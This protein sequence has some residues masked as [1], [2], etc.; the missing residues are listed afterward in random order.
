[1]YSIGLMSGTSMD[2][3]DAALLDTDGISAITELANISISYSM[4]FKI[5]LKALE[6]T[7]KAHVGHL[8]LTKQNFPKILNSYL[9]NELNISDKN[10]KETLQRLSQYL[11][12][13]NHT[14]ITA[15]D[16]IAHST[17][18]HAKAVLSLLKKTNLSA[19][20]IDVIG[21][22][23]QTLFHSPAHKISL[24]I[25]LGDQLADQLGITV[26]NDFR[27]N[28]INHGG[29]GAPFAP[30]YHQ[31]LAIRDHKIPLVV[32]N[33]GGIANVSIICGK[34]E[35]QLFGFDTG[36]GNG[37]IDRYIKQKTHGQE[38][39]DKNG[40]YGLQGNVDMNMFALLY[41]RSIQLHGK[42]FFDIPP[43]KSLDIGD[44]QL[45]EEINELEFRDACAT[46]EAFTA[47]TIVRSID[48][49]PIQPLHW[50][51]AGGGWHNPVIYSELVNRLKLRLGSSVLVETA[52][53][54]GWNNAAM[55]AQIFAYLAVRSLKGLP[56]SYPST[57]LVPYPLSGGHIH[58]PSVG[59]KTCAD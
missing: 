2:G 34:D 52:T 19:N 40:K 18:L 38:H 54:A 8:N 32:V 49:F 11:Y 48:Y 12:K 20:N 44:M 46:L 10:I 21:Y 39:M 26:V 42:N 28:D 16:V 55:E 53:E 4:E 5:L 59:I 41:Q 17:Q 37:L 1:M 13:N 31:A 43:P 30:L 14:S 35:Q 23:G 47:D 58:K 56:I 45:P 7:V 6:M 51:L 22:H 27:S 36:P 25:G 24:Q 29:Q 33:C 9:T 57:T 15:D 50:I 3:I